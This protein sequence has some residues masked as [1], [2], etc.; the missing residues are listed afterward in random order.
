MF[1]PNCKATIL[2]LP[3]VLKKNFHHREQ[4][5]HDIM[6]CLDDIMHLL[7]PIKDYNLLFIDGPGTFINE[8]VIASFRFA[9]TACYADAEFGKRLYNQAYYWQ[10]YRNKIIGPKLCR[11][12][13]TYETSKA[14]L[15]QSVDADITFC[16]MVSAFP[17][18]LPDKNCD[19][20][21]TVSSKQLGAYPV[22][23]IIG[24]KKSLEIE[25]WFEPLPGSTLSIDNY[26][27]FARRHETPTTPSIPLFDDLL[28]ELW[29]LE[30]NGGLKYL[31]KKI[32]E[33]RK[34]LDIGYGEGPVLNL[35]T[36][37]ISKLIADKFNLYK[38]ADGEP[39]IFLY[40]GSDK[41]YEELYDF[42]GKVKT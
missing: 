29:H 35:Y 30:L 8:I 14:R 28:R 15:N 31:R 16:D 11:C 5:F 12:Y 4:S 1:G 18:Y 26:I 23:G 22:I 21:T 3:A 34:A 41:D 27:D 33:R 19:I 6:K 37:E 40:S 42:I 10:A 39:Q 17:Y 38:N 32:N 25:K 13:P 20:F 9:F 36:C 24:I 7:F 2:E